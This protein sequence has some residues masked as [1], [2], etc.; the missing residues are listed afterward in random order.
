[1][2]KYAFDRDGASYR[3]KISLE[4]CL[5]ALSFRPGIITSGIVSLLQ[6]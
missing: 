6:R 3:Q 4:A 1:M 5:V 2:E